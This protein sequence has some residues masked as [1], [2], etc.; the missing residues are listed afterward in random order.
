[1]KKSNSTVLACSLKLFTKFEMFPVTRF[2][3]QK[4]AIFDTEMLTGSRL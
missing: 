3:D 1:M 2:K 4:A